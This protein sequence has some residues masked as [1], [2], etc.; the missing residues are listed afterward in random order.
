[1]AITHGQP[2]PLGDRVF[3]LDG[4]DRQGLGRTHSLAPRRVSGQWVP[5]EFQVHVDRHAA[6]SLARRENVWT[7]ASWRLS[8]R[9]R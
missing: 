3:L 2:Q 9:S 5:P 4:D 7:E 8:R 6:G 1:V